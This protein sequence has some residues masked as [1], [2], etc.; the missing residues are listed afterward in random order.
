[1]AKSLDKI[2]IANLTAST[3]K[4][5]AAGAAGIQASLAALV[6]SDQTRGITAEILCIDDPAQMSAI[7]GNAVG[8]PADER[9]AKAAVDAAF[10]AYSP[11]YILLLDGP[12]V[13]PHITLSAIPGLSDGDLTIPSDLPYASPAGWSRQPSH[14]LSVTRVVGRLPA[15]EGE[16]DA[17]VLVRLIEQAMGHVSGLA[18]DYSPPFSLSADIWKGSTQLS[19]NN[20]FG[21]GSPL[22][23]TPPACHAGI[24]VDLA[25]KAHFINCHGAQADHRF[26]GQSGANY[27]VAMESALAAPHIGA[28]TVAA[29][30]CCYGAELYNYSILGSPE[31]I[32]MSYMKGGATAYVGST[33][34]AYGPATTNGQ[35]DLIAQYFLEEILKGATSGRAFLQARQRFIQSQVM[36][37]PANLKTIAQFLL[38]GDPSLQ[39]CAISSANIDASE[40]NV[41]AKTMALNFLDFDPAAGRKARRTALHSLG[42]AAGAS[43]TAPGPPTVLTKGLQAQIRTI[44]EAQGL[45]VKSMAS[46]AV[47]G[48]SLHRAAAKALDD[49]RK[50][51]V[52]IDRRDEPTRPAPFVRL[53]V[54]HIEAD[55]LVR[56]ETIESR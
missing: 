39:P 40:P 10:A 6:A 15:A 8:S 51:A 18:E 37:N 3:A 11:D 33:N 56:V 27:P 36:A 13:V 20:V 45:D 25:R 52:A 50:V 53:L 2:I 43:A 23:A 1:M 19:V 17:S 55:R 26:Y 7:G 54:A 41:G 29:A 48:G 30:E 22:Q 47:T 34:I 24:D 16:P 32:C 46:F 35:A 14:F 49:K 38:L 12:D 31:P 4:Y 28:G 21:P 9:G 42:L 5:G 44:A